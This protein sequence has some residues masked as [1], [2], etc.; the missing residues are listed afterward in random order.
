[1]TSVY[2][3]GSLQV[4]QEYF[5]NSFHLKLNAMCAD[6]RRPKH[7]RFDVSMECFNVYI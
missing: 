5:R 1:M 2:H 7:S 4:F 3:V 6:F